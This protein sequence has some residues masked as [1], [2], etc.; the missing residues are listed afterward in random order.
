MRIDRASFDRATAALLAIAEGEVDDSDECPV[1]LR[2]EAAQTILSMPIIGEDEELREA[3]KMAFER[4]AE[5]RSRNRGK[6]IPSEER[7]LAIL[8]GDAPS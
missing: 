8:A 5:W 1:E 3:L 2:V 6:R 4:G 7:V